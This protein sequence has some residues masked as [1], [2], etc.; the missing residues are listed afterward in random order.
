MNGQSIQC[1]NSKL[2]SLMTVRVVKE[3]QEHAQSKKV[4]EEEKL[5]ESSRLDQISQNA[6]L[7]IPG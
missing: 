6:G 4:C 1:F 7:M 5:E 3:S 2:G